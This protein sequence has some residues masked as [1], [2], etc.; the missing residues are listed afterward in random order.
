MGTNKTRFVVTAMAA[1]MERDLIRERNLTGCTPRR[2]KAD[3][4]GAQPPHEDLL[5]IARA[6]RA[7]DRESPG[8]RES[9]GPRYTGRSTW[10]TMLPPC[11]GQGGLGATAPVVRGPL[12]SN[13]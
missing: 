12:A 11:T 2:P 7:G 4:P 10:T 8:T 5:A 9:V 13:K 1:E 3:A 6:R